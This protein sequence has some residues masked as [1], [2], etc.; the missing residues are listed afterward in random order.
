MLIF[1]RVS[2]LNLFS[3]SVA[4]RYTAQV[5]MNAGRYQMAN[6]VMNIAKQYGYYPQSYSLQGKIKSM[7]FY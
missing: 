6:S 3:E 2:M 1:L 7:W 4:Y 5:Y